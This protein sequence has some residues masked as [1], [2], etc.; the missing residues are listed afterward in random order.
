[1]L[2][3]VQVQRVVN[4]W[5]LQ[6]GFSVGIGD[7]IAPRD[8]MELISKI[9]SEAKGKVQQTLESAQVRALSVCLS[10]WF[11][12][13]C[14]VPVSLVLV[15]CIVGLTIMPVSC[16]CQECFVLVSVL[17]CSVCVLGSSTHAINHAVTH[18]CS[19]LCVLCCVSPGGQSAQA[20][21]QHHVADVRGHREH[22]SRWRP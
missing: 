9:I 19:C 21:R 20:A 14:I 15:A 6:R 13:A 7:S 12:L 16:A 5:L 2:H 4:H 18:A 3:S 22:H 17:G 11:L 10:Q 1:M 8:T